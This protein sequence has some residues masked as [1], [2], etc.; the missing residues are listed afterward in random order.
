MSE[1]EQI[2]CR[3]EYH[4]KTCVGRMEN[5]KMRKGSEDWNLCMW[6]RV[7]HV[8]A[9]IRTAAHLEGSL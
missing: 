1:P 9:E 5:L 7:L 8:W 2:L 6:C 3:S 4:L